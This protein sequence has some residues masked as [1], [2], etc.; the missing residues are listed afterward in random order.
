MYLTDQASS[1][2]AEVMR[3]LLRPT[4]DSSVASPSANVT[5]FNRISGD[6]GAAVAY[7]MTYA[8]QNR[9]SGISII[10]YRDRMT[11]AKCDKT[12]PADMLRNAAHPWSPDC[13][14]TAFM[15]LLL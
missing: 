2:I 14:C 5:E 9:V 7:A 10:A 12:I 6:L 13:T 8:Y 1:C 15:T 3:R 11:L 4:S